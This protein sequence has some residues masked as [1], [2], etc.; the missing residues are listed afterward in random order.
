MLTMCAPFL[1][2]GQCERLHDWKLAHGLSFLFSTNRVHVILLCLDIYIDIQ[3]I[4]SLYVY[5]ST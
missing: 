3:D 2:I 1:F 5:R 4:A